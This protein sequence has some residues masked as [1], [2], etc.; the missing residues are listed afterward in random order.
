MVEFEDIGDL[1]VVDNGF[2]V[3]M[4]LMGVVVLSERGYNLLEMGK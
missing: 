3:V 1:V 2:W 4:V